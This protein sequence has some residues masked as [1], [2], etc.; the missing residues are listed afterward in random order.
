LFNINIIF[1]Y[2]SSIKGA[3]ASFKSS[4][5]LE[6]IEKKD[7]HEATKINAKNFSTKP[8]N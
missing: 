3:P 8:L 2:I 7:R 6:K 1:Y 5:R 4:S